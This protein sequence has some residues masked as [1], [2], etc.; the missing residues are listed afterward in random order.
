MSVTYVELDDAI[1]RQGLRMVVVG[2]IPSPWGEA[3]KGIFHVKGIDWV[4]V[5]LAYDDD[6]LKQWAGGRNGPVA[7]YGKEPPRNRWIDILLLAERLAPEPALLPADLEERALAIGLS[8]EICGEDGLG[9]SRR[10]QLIHA[11]LSG[12]GGFPEHVARYLARKY[13]YRAD[14]HEATAKRVIG[15]LGLFAERLKAQARGGC[16]YLVGPAMSA[17]DIHLATAMAMFAPLPAA[18]C[19]MDETMR[20][21]MST[22]DAETGRALDAILLRHRDMMYERHLELPLSL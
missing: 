8:H 9:W 21:A 14:A 22:L 2:G 13:G 7:I 15:L 3:A 18:V 17:A 12:E 11:G 20:G 5:R 10:N 19:A 16:D 4:A 6:A 1:A